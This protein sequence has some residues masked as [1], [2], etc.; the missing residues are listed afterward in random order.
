MPTVCKI[1][2]QA[3]V[4]MKDEN[5]SLLSGDSQSTGCGHYAGPGKGV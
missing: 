5:V 3:L 2:G 4:R 1:G